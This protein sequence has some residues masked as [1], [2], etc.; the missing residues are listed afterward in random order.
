[1]YL[2]A[3]SILSNF[4]WVVH[5]TAEGKL[6]KLFSDVD[7]VMW[8]KSHHLMWCVGVFVSVIHISDIFKFFWVAHL[9]PVGNLGKLF[10]NVDNM[11]WRNS[12][13][14]MWCV[15]VFVSVIHISDVFKLFASC[16]FNSWRQ[17]V[18]S[19][20]FNEILDNFQV[21]FS[22][23]MITYSFYCWKHFLKPVKSFNVCMC[24]NW[25]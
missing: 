13:H 12:H 17:V 6:G 23:C 5:L 20:F 10:S 25:S 21:V 2:S 24:W 19:A 8:R 15:G 22:T 7:N 1:M 16:S 18:T 11:M 3:S 4:F 14:R 9:T